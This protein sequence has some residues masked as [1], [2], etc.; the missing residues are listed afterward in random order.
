[1]KVHVKAFAKFTA[2]AGVDMKTMRDL[3]KPVAGKEAEIDISNDASCND[4]IEASR[5]ALG[6]D[7]MKFD[8][9]YLEQKNDEKINPDL[10]LSEIG[11]K[12]GSHIHIVFFK[13]VN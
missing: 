12:D 7:G 3:V 11:V 6:L 13:K 2:L 8:D 9:V 10:K 5:S 4:L 1:M